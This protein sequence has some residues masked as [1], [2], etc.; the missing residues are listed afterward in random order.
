MK[1]SPVN[2]QVT[3]VCA[4]LTIGFC[5]PL[6]AKDYFSFMIHDTPY[7]TNP[8]MPPM[9]LNAVLTYNDITNLATNAS[10]RLAN[11]VA[12]Q[13][14][15]LLPIGAPPIKVDALSSGLE[16]GQYLNN[17][18]W[19][20]FTI[21]LTPTGL[22][23]AA[24]GTPL[25]YEAVTEAESDLYKRF[26]SRVI[27]RTISSH[28]KVCDD[29]N[30]S[31]VPSTPYFGT[32]R[33]GVTGTAGYPNSSAPDVSNIANLEL[34]EPSSFATLSPIYFSIDVSVPGYSRADILRLSP[35]DT[36][37]IYKTAPSLGLNPTTDNID[38]LALNEF[39]TNSPVGP[40]GWYSLTRTS[41][42]LAANAL[43]AADIFE[44]RPSVNYALAGGLPAQLHMT[45][46][47][48]G[49][50]YSAVPT[51][52]ADID[53]ISHLD[54]DTPF[55]WPRNGPVV[56]SFGGGLAPGDLGLGGAPDWFAATLDGL[57][58][59]I[60]QGTATQVGL[61]VSLPGDYRTIEVRGRAGAKAYLSTSIVAV[62][63]TVPRV[64]NLIASSPLPGVVNWQ[65]QNPVV[66]NFIEVRLDDAAPQLLAPTT[67]FSSTGLLPGMHSIEVRGVL[68]AVRSEPAF[69]DIHLAPAVGVRPPENL[70]ATVA[71]RDVF[72]SWT[73]PV[74][75]TQLDVIVNAAA[76]ITTLTLPGGTTSTTLF[77][78]PYGIHNLR[79]RGFIGSQ[80][81]EPSEVE[82]EVVIPLPGDVLRSFTSPGQQYAGIAQVGNLLYVTD[83][84]NDVAYRF[85]KNDFA[86]PIPT[87]PSPIGAATG[88][89][90][91]D[92]L[93]YWANFSSL[94]TTDLNGNNPQPVGALQDEF[95]FFLNPGDIEIDA[96]GTLWAANVNTGEVS[97]H[98]RFTGAYQ[99]LTYTHPLGGGAIFGVTA[100]GPIGLLEVSHG[101]SG[102]THASA[103]DGG[104]RPR[105]GIALP[106]TI[107]NPRG[108]EFDP[109]GIQGVAALYV[110][111]ADGTL[112]EVAAVDPLMAP[113]RED[114]HRLDGLVG[115]SAAVGPIPIPDGSPSGVSVSL[116]VFGPSITVGDLDV[117][118]E[119]EHEFAADVE[120]M[121]VSPQGTVAQ[122]VA[123]GEQASNFARRI[124]DAAAPGAVNDG[125]GT[126]TSATPLATFDGENASG[127]W[128]LMVFDMTPG[129]T[130]NLLRCELSICPETAL[131]SGPNFR[132]ADANA[133]GALNIADAIFILSWLFAA[134]SPTPSCVDAADAND[135]GS[136]NIGDAI[137]VLSA[138]FLAGAPPPPPPGSVCGP[139]PT[140]DALGCL[141][142][143]PCP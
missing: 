47:S 83:S 23:G 28:T 117:E 30:A 73:N 136:G 13:L 111:G 93:L 74:G 128:T 32:T 92:G 120:V 112:L 6:V 1:K 15:P 129:R 63:S 14:Q 80:A 36:I 122:L 121:L 124:D 62:P 95:G 77:N 35:T 131:P 72:L 75:F 10:V 43:S 107:P 123:S 79:V 57:T 87:I 40:V 142:F 8:E 17:H 140:A 70:V 134:G 48:L 49:L 130:G 65:W 4:L 26:D 34:L 42:S 115:T 100:R 114:C 16:I 101:V 109:S 108:I 90:E 110:V 54:P 22:K 29:N 85:D 41:A 11:A 20:V 125:F 104:A 81:S 113:D 56:G 133:D 27:T 64:V 33:A 7:A 45:A 127:D 58:F 91:F 12:A 116:I 19:F 2:R 139:D 44:F 31:A 68:G 21:S 50:L 24:K 137:F 51:S 106:P 105:S 118:L 9:P 103:T 102:I 97:S 82:A 88:I 143:P 138:L 94:W 53:G 99:G 46:E 119:I 18:S 98:S 76:P 126:R 39:G 89:A 69:A 60:Q 55:P 5:A 66:Y 52:D 25:Y 67:F 37:T 38:A 86:L 3:V 59:G 71:G 132:R 61:P 96:S 84:V 135:D 141:A 78:L